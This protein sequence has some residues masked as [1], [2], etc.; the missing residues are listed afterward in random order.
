MTVD[1]GAVKMYTVSSNRKARNKMIEKSNS[2][3]TLMNNL[4]Q[5]QQIEFNEEHHGTL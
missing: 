4:H 3:Y 5:L 2:P 1:F